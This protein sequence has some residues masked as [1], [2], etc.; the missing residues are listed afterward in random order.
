[1]WE[2]STHPVW[3]EYLQRQRDRWD[4]KPIPNGRAMS[5]TEIWKGRV[6]FD[7]R[8]EVLVAGRRLAQIKAKPDDAWDTPLSQP[9]N[10][11]PGLSSDITWTPD[12]LSSV[13]SFGVPAESHSDA[14]MVN[15]VNDA[16]SV[17]QEP[18]GEPTL[19]PP[20]AMKAE[21]APVN[22]E[23]TGATTPPAPLPAVVAHA[24]GSGDSFWLE[25]YGTDPYEYHN[26]HYEYSD[27]H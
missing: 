9:W 12:P 7:R 11:N 19:S 20:L 8:F 21:S 4:E 18:A 5:V 14:E 1:M 22:A 26:L 15:V 2:S 17:V 10:A 25:G 13:I 16:P 27:L 3:R 23:P 6:K 24:P